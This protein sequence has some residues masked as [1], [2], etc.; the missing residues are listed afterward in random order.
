MVLKDKK[1]ILVLI[2]LNTIIAILVKYKTTV[3]KKLLIPILRFEHRT[4][5][6]I[7][8]CSKQFF[9]TSSF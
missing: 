5:Y 3:G 9:I 7:C 6:F 1:N 2:V 8:S 4:F